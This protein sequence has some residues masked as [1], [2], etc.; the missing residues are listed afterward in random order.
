MSSARFLVALLL[1]VGCVVLGDGCSSC[2]SPYDYSGPTLD[3]KGN[4]VGG[5]GT[6]VGSVWAG[7]EPRPPRPT[8]PNV[9]SPDAEGDEKP[10]EPAPTPEAT[11]PEPT[12]DA[13]P[14]D[15]AELARALI[16]PRS[17]RAQYAAPSSAAEEGSPDESAQPEPYERP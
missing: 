14:S 11:Q 15:P 4:P 7:T 1:C 8:A 5:F 9:A 10:A 2:Q 6:R 13:T 16:A 17:K 12:A 3:A